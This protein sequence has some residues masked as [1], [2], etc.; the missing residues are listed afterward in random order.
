MP[1][2]HLPIL[3]ECGHVTLWRGESSSAI[4]DF[5]MWC[6]GGC[7]EDVK[8]QAV[9]TRSWR[10]AC[11]TEGCRWSR[12]TAQSEEL[13]KYHRNAHIRRHPRHVVSIAYQRNRDLESRIRQA[14]GRNVYVGIPGFPQKG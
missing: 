11:R 5:S 8:I 13:A 2:I 12:K 7:E 3:L 6:M 1:S 14:L 9:E 10:A 4:P